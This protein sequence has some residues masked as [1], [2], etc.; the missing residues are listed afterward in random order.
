MIPRHQAAVGSEDE[1]GMDVEDMGS[2]AEKLAGAKVKVS[3]IISYNAV[4]L[5]CGHP[6]PMAAYC[7]ISDMC[8][9]K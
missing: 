4:I 9:C 7:V 6:R 2:V 3:F 5:L 1:E 8:E